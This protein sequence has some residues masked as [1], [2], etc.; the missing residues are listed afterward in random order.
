V[1]L[2]SRLLTITLAAV[3]AMLGVVAV[4]AYVR[5]ANER[6]VNGLKAE[7]VMVANGAIPAGTSLSK[8]QQ[9]HLLSTEKVPDSSLTTPAVQSVTAAN[10]H[11]V[12]SSA[13]AKGQVLLQNMVASAASVTANGGFLIPSGMQAVAIN[14]C[15]PEAVAGYL[16]PGSRVDVYNTIASSNQIQ[17]TCDTSRSFISGSGIADNKFN[18][19][20]IVLKNAEV[21]AVGQNPATPSTSGDN[22]ATVTT[23]PSSSSS[24]SQDE[25]LVTL[26]VNQA[27]AERLILIGEVGLPYMALLGSNANTAF[28]PPVNLFQPQQQP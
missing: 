16:T 5:Q 13:V 22:S 2:K 20:L 17:R 24:S 26:A 7:T 4:L 8:A 10:E 6:A 1:I 15:I 23:D 12:M 21:L 18:T 3:L 11:L 28:T 19:T 9:E 27:D 14:M 25:V